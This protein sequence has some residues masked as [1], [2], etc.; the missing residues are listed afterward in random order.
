MSEKTFG[1]KRDALEEWMIEEF[2]DRSQRRD[3]T[4]ADEMLEQVTE[5]FEPEDL[6]PDEIDE[7]RKQAHADGQH[8]VELADL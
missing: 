2:E 8:G 5:R 6:Y 3:I 4:S 7:M 1:E